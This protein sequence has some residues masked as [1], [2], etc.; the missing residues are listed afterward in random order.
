[1]QLL[2]LLLAFASHRIVSTAPGIT[3]ILFA[4]GAGDQVVGDTTYCNY[5]EAAKTKAKIGGFT[6]PSIE[7]I[8][9][10]NPDLVFMS[11]NRPDIAKNLQQSRRIE[12][13]T[14]QADSVSGIY[15]SIQ[16]IAD[17]IG[18]GERGKAL[19]QSIDKEI[20]E[21]APQS[22][23]ATKPRILFVVGRTPGTIGDLIVVGRGSYLSELI[24]LAGGINVASDAAVQYPQFSFEEVIHRDPDIIIDMGHDE[25]VSEAAK[26]KVKQL[27]QK[28]PFLRAVKNDK[29]FPISA[30]Y[31]LTP[32][33]RVGQAVRDLRNI[34]SR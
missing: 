15:L 26:R 24:E 9:A 16:T 30:E 20:H 13:V 4:L 17:K 5:P 7:L 18:I 6:T 21:N 33:P 3:E 28:Y 31:F 8:L 10:L 27:W 34:F 14:V 2:L 22:N 19:V 11:D 1:M 32:G 29:V 23:K 12:V 25:M